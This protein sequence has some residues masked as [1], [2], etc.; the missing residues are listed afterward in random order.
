M[1]RSLFI[2]AAL[3][4]GIVP[5]CSRSGPDPA[6]AARFDR[7][8]A[9]ASPATT[10]ADPGRQPLPE[11]FGAEATVPTVAVFDTPGAARPV[12]A[13]SN[14]TWEKVP[15]AF[16][17]VERQAEWLKVQLNVRPNG[18]TGWIRASDVALFDLP[19]RIVVDRAAHQLTLYQGY[20]VVL[21]ASVAVGTGG[22]PTPTGAYYVDAIVKLVNPHTVWGP[23]QL[24]VSAFSDV[25]HRFGGGSGQI[26]IHGTNAPGLVG[27]NVSHGCVRMKNPDITEVA[28][29]I[30]LGTPVDI[31]D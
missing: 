11:R 16:M 17:V 2:V 26:A 8:A 22:A 28:S 9:S 3:A 30:S 29:R 25:F 13:M 27:R 10:V 24:S 14:P 20:N 7:R 4:A 18:S 12:R 5:A 31:V 6:A 1:R 15:L 21:S 19:Y 23:Y